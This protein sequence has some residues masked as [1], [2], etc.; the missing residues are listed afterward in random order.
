MLDYR[1]CSWKDNKLY[2]EG[3]F[4]GISLIPTL[5][6]IKYE[7]GVISEDVYNLTRAHDNAKRHYIN[8]ENTDGRLELEGARKELGSPP[9]ALF[10][11]ES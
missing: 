6:K 2:Y 9:D 3:K 7:D 11:T 1:R 5:F 10:S 4:T 8:K